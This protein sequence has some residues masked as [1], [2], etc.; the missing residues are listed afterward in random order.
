M[1]TLGVLYSKANKDKRLGLNVP[2]DWDDM[3]EL[4][5]KY[6]GLQTDEAGDGLLYQRLPAEIERWLVRSLALDRALGT[7]RTQR[8]ASWLPPSTSRSLTKTF[9]SGDAGVP[10]LRPAD[11]DGTVRAGSSRCSGPRAAASPR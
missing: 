1:V 4:M 10:C 7:R 11:L 9:G 2:A 5:K 3:L 6:N 8:V